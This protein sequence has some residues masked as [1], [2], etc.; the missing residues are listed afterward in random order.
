MVLSLIISTINFYRT[1]NTHHHRCILQVLTISN[2]QCGLLFS[3]HVLHA[4]HC[5]PCAIIIVIR[6]PHAQRIAIIVMVRTY[7]EFLHSN[8]TLSS[9]FS[10]RSLAISSFCIDSFFRIIGSTMGAH[11]LQQSS[12]SLSSV[13]ASRQSKQNS[14]SHSSQ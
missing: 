4:T 11:P 6:Q 13:L 7:S 12:P 3:N 10:L 14:L 9:S 8:F 5:F 1:S 2:I